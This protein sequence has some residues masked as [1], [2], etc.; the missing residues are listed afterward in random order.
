MLR[1]RTI[2]RK[3]V[4][5]E[6][7]EELTSSGTF[8]VPSGCTSIDAF[9]VGA[10]GGGGSGGS[11]YPGAGGGAGY[12]KVY[13]GISVTPGQKLTVKI[14]QGKSNNSLD[15]NGVDGE[16]SY[17]INTSYSAQGGKGGLYGT[18]N[19]E[20]QKAHGGNGG[21]GGGA[22]YQQGGTNGGNGGTY[23][24]YLG[25]YGQGST[26]KCPFND[27]LY[28]SGG[29]GGNDSDKGKDGINNTGNGGDGGRGGMNGF[30]RQKSTYGGSGIIVLHYFKYK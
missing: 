8:I 26:T 30:S 4:L 19:P 6:V 22:P 13:Y 2:G 1:R 7:V 17:F 29:K 12:T 21:S 20:T 14:G 15:S 3:K 5:I 11:Y 23:Y 27:K 10:G 9:V 18:G 28:A 24:S 16:Y 25:G